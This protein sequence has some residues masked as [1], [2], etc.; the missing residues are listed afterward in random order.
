MHE[1]S[2]VEALIEQV[3]VEVARCGRGG[4]VLGLDLVIGRLSGVNVDSIRFA[5][6]VLSPGTIVEGSRMNIDEPK[7][8][9]CCRSCKSRSPI[10]DLE[11]ECPACGSDDITIEGGQEMLLKTIELEDP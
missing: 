2:I 3:G 10:D 8:I 6:E 9:C 11:A 5:F 1:A 4:R 7:A